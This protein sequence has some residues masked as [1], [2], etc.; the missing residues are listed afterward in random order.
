MDIHTKTGQ[1]LNKGAGSV[2]QVAGQPSGGAAYDYSKP[3][4]VL[5]I[6]LMVAL[7][8]Q[9]KPCKYRRYNG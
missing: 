2:Q 3:L 4:Q 5:N 9:K 8:A 6:H 7:A 1:I